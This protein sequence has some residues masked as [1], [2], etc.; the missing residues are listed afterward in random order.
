MATNTFTQV[1]GNAW[2]TAAN[3]SLGRVPDATDAVVIQDDCEV[4]TDYS[5]F[6]IPSIS[7]GVLGGSTAVLAMLDGAHLVCT[8][9]SLQTWPFA[10]PTYSTIEFRP[11][12]SADSVILDAAT[13]SFEASKIITTQPGGATLKT[14]NNLVATNTYQHTTL[15]LL[16]TSTAHAKIEFG[17]AKSITWSRSASAECFYAELKL[18]YC[19]ISNCAAYGIVLTEASVWI[20]NCKFTGAGGI[21]LDYCYQEHI[22]IRNCEFDCS[23]SVGVRVVASNVRFDSCWIHDTSGDQVLFV[24]LQATSGSHVY[25][26]GGGIGVDPSGT[27]T[28]VSYGLDLSLGTRVITIATDTS[29]CTTKLL[30]TGGA[31]WIEKGQTTHDT[32][33]T[34]FTAD[35]DQYAVYT[36][37]SSPLILG[38]D[39]GG[40]QG[41]T[42]LHCDDRNAS[43]TYGSEPGVPFVFPA[44]DGDVVTVVATVKNATLTA[45]LGGVTLEVGI[46]GAWGTIATD[47][48]DTLTL[49]NEETLSA[50]FTLDDDRITTGDIVTVH[51]R[52]YCAADAPIYVTFESTDVNTSTE[53]ITVAGHG[54]TSGDMVNF[55]TT[56]TLPAP[57]AA[58]TDYY[59][60][61]VDA[62]TVTV[63]SSQADG[64]SGD[65]PIDLTSAGSSPPESH[66]IRAQGRVT[67]KDI[68]ITGS[69]VD[70]GDTDWWRKSAPAVGPVFPLFQT[71][72]GGGGSVIGGVIVKG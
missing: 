40:V 5:A 49:T 11:A 28:A 31:T 59:V 18:E 37:W 13:L 54:L 1:S 3:W 48:T 33:F 57:L 4:S 39:S 29:Q 58:A 27:N 8:S 10:T 22:H 46:T 53:Q 55:T 62:N 69:S 34:K 68:A 44:T 30:S 56:A 43:S 45:L 41:E 26:H 2:E 38:S 15:Q 16:G 19:D 32:P 51:G 36:E 14:D 23:G 66:T 61:A 42:V 25:W 50:E 47:T 67:V 24:G 65:N 64:I 60:N 70:G 63:H 9:C 72:T 35:V 71:A 52:V 20:E 21:R 6:T 12:N 17:V 7:V